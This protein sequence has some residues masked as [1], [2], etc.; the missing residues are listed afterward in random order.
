MG[1]TGSVGIDQDQNQEFRY[2]GTKG[3]VRQDMIHG[4]A[5]AFFNDGTSEVI[6]DLDGDD[7]YPLERPA[8]VLADLTIG[9]GVNLAPGRVAAH[10]VALVGG[11]IPVCGDGHGSANRPAR[12]RKE[13]RW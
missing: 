5:D 8:R 3:Q 1:A 7:I 10:T 12:W 13:S 4:R 11:R 9:E 6:P 2:Y